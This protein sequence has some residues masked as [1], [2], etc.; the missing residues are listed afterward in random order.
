VTRAEKIVA[1][2]VV[3]FLVLQAAFAPLA[4]AKTLCIAAATAAGTFAAV[5][6]GARR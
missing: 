5:Y 4:F 3:A 6:L 2:I 1:A